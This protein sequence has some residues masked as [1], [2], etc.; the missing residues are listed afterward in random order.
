MVES[1][2]IQSDEEG[3][4][5]VE[6]FLE[7]FFDTYH[8]SNYSASISVAVLSA[9]RNAVV[10]GNGS[11]P[12][13]QVRIEAGHCR[14]GLFFLV[15]DQGEGFDYSCYLNSSNAKLSNGLFLIDSLSDKVEFFNGGS[16]VRM[17]FNI[18][19]I[20]LPDAM[21]RASRLVEFFQPQMAHI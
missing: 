16:T 11:N 12:V 13:R 19:G 2:V 18:D 9:V 15:Q 10:H 20:Y 8:V 1:I 14:G 4:L 6:R 7:H 3:I 21:S 5:A 17:E